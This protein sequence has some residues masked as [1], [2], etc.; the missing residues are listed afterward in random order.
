MDARRWDRAGRLRVGA[1]LAALVA[2]AGC[3]GGSAGAPSSS[4]S[5]TTP[6][7]RAPASSPATTDA[8]ASASPTSTLSAEEQQAVAEAT[9]TVLAYRQTIAD[10]YSGTRT[11]LN[12]LDQVATGE[13][14][15]ANLMGVQQGLS[16]GQRSR[17]AGAKLVLVS[18]E[19]VR[20]DLG[21]DLDSIRIRACIDATAVTDISPEGVQTQGGRESLD[22][23]VV[24]TD[25]LA[26]PGWAI[27]KVEGKSDPES[28][29]C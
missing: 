5:A 3:G 1:A 23:L 19:P 9:A 4:A 2:L 22:Y 10:L 14:L 28:R 15:D 27:A 13:L 24:R 29:A 12:D 6:S 21:G 26:D 17:P 25:Y 8:S 16:R 20:I 18:V 11:N 7:A